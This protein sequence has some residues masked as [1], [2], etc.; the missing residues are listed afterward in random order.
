M[1]YLFTNRIFLS[2]PEKG[3]NSSDQGRLFRASKKL[4]GY[5]DS[6][7]FTHCEDKA[8]LLNEIGKFFVRKIVKIHD[9]ID[10]KAI[11]TT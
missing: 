2:L 4:L 7:L 1:K 5:N 11:S 10:A 8:L 9:Q 3:V 6:P